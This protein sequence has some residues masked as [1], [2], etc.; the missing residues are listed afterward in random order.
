MLPTKATFA[1]ASKSCHRHCCG[2][3]GVTHKKNKSRKKVSSEILK[4]KF[5]FVFYAFGKSS[6]SRKVRFENQI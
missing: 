6:L 1:S 3:L 5:L 4:L 2:T